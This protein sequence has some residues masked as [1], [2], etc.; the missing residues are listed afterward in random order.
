MTAVAH[1]ETAFLQVSAAAIGESKTNAMGRALAGQT[2]GPI[3]T[4]P[5]DVVVVW[6]LHNVNGGMSINL[7]SCI[8]TL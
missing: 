8:P 3:V 2:S 1:C 5:F 7:P 6:R 4:A